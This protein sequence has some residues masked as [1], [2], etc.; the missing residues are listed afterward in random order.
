MYGS[1]DV[2]VCVCVWMYVR[3]YVC[4]MYVLYGYDVCVC[5]CVVNGLDTARGPI[6]WRAGARWTGT[7]K[8]GGHA[9]D[10]DSMSLYYTHTA[11]ASSWWCRSQR[12]DC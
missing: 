3:L 11:V 7:A 12:R 2:R 9:A 6:L 10:G 1:V 5:V 8:P 4:R